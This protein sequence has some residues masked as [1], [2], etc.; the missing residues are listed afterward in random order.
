MA[1]GNRKRRASRAGVNSKKAMRKTDI[2][3]IEAGMEAKRA[4]ERTF[5]GAVE[6]VPDEALFVVD[7]KPAGSGKRGGK[8]TL[9]Q[10][11]YLQ[12]NP[13]IK[14]MGGVNKRKARGA[15]EASFS[16]RKRIEALAEKIAKGQVQ[17]N[18]AGAKKK[19]KGGADDGEESLEL[20][21]GDETY[22]PAPFDPVKEGDRAPK[23][24][25]R[26]RAEKRLVRPNVPRITSKRRAVEVDHAGN[27]YNPSQQAHR[28]RLQAAW[29]I[30]SKQQ[31][32]IEIAN[33]K[34]AAPQHLLEGDDTEDPLY[35]GEGGDDDDESSNDSGKEVRR[36]PPTVNN[37]LTRAQRNKLARRK[38]QEEARRLKLQEKEF[39]KTLDK[40]K[41]IEKEVVTEEKQSELRQKERAEKKE[42][43]MYEP[44]RIG[45][46]L[47]KE[48]IGDLL[49][50][51]ELPGSLRELPKTGDALVD[52]YKS[53]QKRNMVETRVR[54]KKK[55]RYQLKMKEKGYR[56]GA[57]V[58][59]PDNASVV[60]GVM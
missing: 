33:A 53:M 17:L 58:E 10:E 3:D 51:D 7:K 15:K 26:T 12:G 9:Y 25:P 28:E 1:K 55:R 39:R 45:K 59:R 47:Y 56:G 48:T 5:G 49:L 30:E 21:W 38:A 14:P 36:N 22:H 35:A 32:Q 41:D 54:V 46:R 11:R 60:P 16:E 50:T 23:L 8:K 18:T 57:S 43:A 27:S 20:L 31:K 40:L 34:L 19:K 2:S 37:K 42:K 6:Q 29:A 52:R 24:A 4:E 44:Q 13:N